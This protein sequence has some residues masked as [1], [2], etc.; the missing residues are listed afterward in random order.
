MRFVT[1]ENN[2]FSDRRFG[3]L[4]ETEVVDLSTSSV[5]DMRTFISRG[6]TLIKDVPF[7]IKTGKNQIPLN[8]VKIRAPIY[9]P[10]KIICVG[11]NYRDHAIESGMPIP[12]EPVLFSK[13]ASCII[14]PDDK[15]IKPPET[16]QLDYEVELVVVIG[17]EG[18]RIEKKDAFN[19]V[20]GYTIGHDVSARDWQLGKP[21]GQ[22][23]AGKTFDTFGPIGPAIVTS[24]SDPHNLNI[25]CTL[26]GK[27]MQNSNTSQFIF[28][29][30]ELISYISNICT[31]KPGDLIFTGTPPGVGFGRKPPVYLNHGDHIKCSISE[32]G[33]LENIVD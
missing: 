5:T 19:Y 24:V 17:K 2:K 12:K 15:I 21:S 3:V 4:L 18:K 22:W 25:S 32:L 26:N 33:S 31:L 20:F 29:I 8:Q 13:F 30:D 6:S 7:A 1:F 28:K 14:G 9:N 23:L 11:L 16:T 10:E 27:I